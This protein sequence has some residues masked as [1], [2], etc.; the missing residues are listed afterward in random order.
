MI[1]NADDRA[2]KTAKLTSVINALPSKLD[3]I[4]AVR[5]AT[6]IG[7]REALTIV[8]ALWGADVKLGAPAP[9]PAPAPSQYEV[10]WRCSRSCSDLRDALQMIGTAASIASVSTIW[11]SYQDE[12]LCVYVSSEEGSTD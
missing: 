11:L 3:A 1:N 5:E 7:L 9:A 6:N 4:K 2:A 10:S 8:E 12:T